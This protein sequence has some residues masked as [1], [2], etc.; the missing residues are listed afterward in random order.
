MNYVDFRVLIP[1]R[2][3]FQVLS[4]NET[5]EYMDNYMKMFDI[6]LSEWVAQIGVPELIAE[7]DRSEVK[8]ALVH[9]EMN[10]GHISHALNE[11][12][13][14]A[15]S[16]APDRLLGV[17]TVDPEVDSDPVEVLREARKWGAVGMNIQGW[18]LRRQIT[19]AYFY[20]A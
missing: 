14:T 19:D 18:V 6:D 3:Q 13:K 5:P 10:W 8:L 4:A 9:A 17:V 7:M 16:K 12:A 20:P 2:E 15:V 1:P 11:A